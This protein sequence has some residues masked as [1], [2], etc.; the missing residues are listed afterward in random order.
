M[1]GGLM[2]GFVSVARSF[3]LDPRAFLPDRHSRSPLSHAGFSCRARVKAAR[4]AQTPH[5]EDDVRRP[6]LGLGPQSP[7]VAPPVRATAGDADGSHEHTARLNDLRAEDMLDPDAHHG[8]RPVALLGLPGQR[9]APLALAVD[10]AGQLSGFEHR[11]DPGRAPGGVG[12]DPGT[13]I[14]AR[15]QFIHHL[16]AMRG[17]VA[18]VI[19]PDQL[20]F[21]VHIDVVLVAA[22]RRAVLPGPDRHRTTGINVFLGPF[23]RFVFPIPGH[24]ARFDRHVFL[25]FVVGAKHRHNPSV[26]TR[27]RHSP[28]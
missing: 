10:V 15:Q 24:L 2:G 16:A 26:P 6:D 8:F 13:G 3:G 1:T 28:V 19:L 4:L 17:G 7:R 20:V 5:V 21:S 27:V 22:M 12:P 25:A 9:L 14:T 11:L 23:R 18:D